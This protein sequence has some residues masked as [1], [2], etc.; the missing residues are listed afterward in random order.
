MR[1]ELTF[2][3][4]PLGRCSMP[5]C[6]APLYAELIDT[7][8]PARLCVECSDSPAEALHRRMTGV[9]GAQCSEACC[10]KKAA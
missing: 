1:G 10:R 2:K 7:S 6:G 4:T 9:S 3:L 8:K 5:T